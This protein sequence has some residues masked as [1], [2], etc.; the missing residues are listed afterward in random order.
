MTSRSEELRAKA[1]RHRAESNRARFLGA[2]TGVRDDERER[3]MVDAAERMKATRTWQHDGTAPLALDDRPRPY[4][5]PGESVAMR[6]EVALGL[7]AGLADAEF[8]AA[9]LEA[10]AMD[11][12]EQGN[13][14]LE[15]R[16]AELRQENNLL[17][18]KAI[19]LLGRLSDRKRKA[20]ATE[21]QRRKAGDRRRRNAR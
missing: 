20:K 4:M 2:R 17:A 10:A 3:L 21:A 5:V 14:R 13:E 9:W 8:R 16:I 1:E 18:A 11:R 15:R 12:W 19:L 7:L 6:A